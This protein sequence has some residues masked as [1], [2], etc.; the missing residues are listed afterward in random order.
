M[1]GPAKDTHVTTPVAVGMTMFGRRP[2]RARNYTETVLLTS[3]RGLRLVYFR[4]HRS[5]FTELSL[6][7]FATV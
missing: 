5:A 6:T 7:R 2:E 4:A 1:T 3:L